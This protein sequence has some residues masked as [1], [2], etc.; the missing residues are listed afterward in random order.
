MTKTIPPGY[1]LPTGDLGDDDI[2]CQLVFL[3]D[4]PEYWQALVGALSYMATWRAW[5]RDTDK[6]GKNA[7]ANWREA[8]ELTMECWRM[9]CLQDLQDDVAAILAIMQLGQSC[10]DEQDVTNGDQYTDRVVDGVG[11]VPQNIIDAGYASGV[12]DWA[13]FDDYKCMISHVI[14]DQ[15]PAKLLEFSEIVTPLG[16]VAGGLAAVAGIIAVIFSTAGL[17]IA[18][19]IVANIGSMSLLYEA[20]IGFGS[21]TTLAAKVVTNHDE[22]ACAI[23]NSDGDDGALVALNDKIDEL[24]TTVEGVILKNMNIGPT[25]KSLYAGRYDQQDIAEILYDAGYEVDDFTCYCDEVELN[26]WRLYED[27]QLLLAGSVTPPACTTSGAKAWQ[28]WQYPEGSELLDGDFRIK[29]YYLL[30]GDITLGSNCTGSGLM[31]FKLNMEVAWDTPDYP[32]SPVWQY[33]HYDESNHPPGTQQFRHD[34]EITRPYV[35]VRWITLTRRLQIEYGS[36]DVELEMIITEI[37]HTP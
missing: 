34:F 8:F 28:V 12:S 26:G 25:L 37:E 13:G 22:L 4:R 20:L 35:N 36:C 14:V 24:F 5:E 1:P 18:F 17:A 11:D 33:V 32:G 10:C 29:G 31:Q 19:G 21:L 30:T 9:A 6:R 27:P 15:L 16:V 2:V 7:A 23:Y 3:P